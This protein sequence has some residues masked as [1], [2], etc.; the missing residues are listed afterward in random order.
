[1]GTLKRHHVWMGGAILVVLTLLS[2]CGSLGGRNAAP[3]NPVS[4]PPQQTAGPAPAR[5][6]SAPRPYFYDF[7]DIPTPSE[8]RL[9][10]DESYTFQSGN[11][12]AGLLTLRGRVDVNSV[13]NFF[14]MAL[15]KENWK[16]KGG[17]RYKRSV[18]I[19]EKAERSCIINLYE[20]LYYTYVEIYVAPSSGRI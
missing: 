4:Q 7:P 20:K 3:P 1:M 14:Q 19:F 12:K 6:T 5:E 15:P 8:L 2:G 16:P 13:I 10:S 17:F 9:V 11:Q 18:L